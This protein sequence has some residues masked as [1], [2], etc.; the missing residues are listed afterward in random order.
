MALVATAV[1][2]ASCGSA[3]AGNAATVVGRAGTVEVIHPFVPAP[4]SPSVAAFYVTLRN[5]GSTADTLIGASTAV[6]SSATMHAETSVGDMETMT[7]LAGVTVPGDREVTLAPGHD[8][9]MLEGL[10][11]PVRQ[12][13]RLTMTLRFAHGGSVT[14][15]VP[16]VPLTSMAPASMGAR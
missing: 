8:H 4:P 13:Q 5:T 10:R 14:F 16:V 2:A 1:V 12:G 7:P 11:V 3:P 15:P 6:A 9:V